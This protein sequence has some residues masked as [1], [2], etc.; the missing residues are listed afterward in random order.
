MLVLPGARGRRTS[1]TAPACGEPRPGRPRDVLSLRP[2]TSGVGYRAIGGEPTRRIEEIL[3]SL[4]A[5]VFDMQVDPRPQLYLG[6][7]KLLLIKEV[8]A[9]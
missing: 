6:A 8:P 1:G 5:V 3:L 7:L 4:H 9:A 2:S